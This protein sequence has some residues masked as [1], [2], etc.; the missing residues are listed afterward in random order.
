[1]KRS[2]EGDALAGITLIDTGILPGYSWHR[3][4]RIWRTPVLGEAF[5]AVSRGRAFTRGLA[6][7]EPRGLPA[8]FLAGMASHYD[9]RTKRAVLKLYR[10]TDEPGEGA[11][12]L[13]AAFAGREVPALV[14]WG[15]DDAYLPSSYAERQR[16]VFPAAEVHVLPDSGHWP[17]ADSPETV[18]RLLVEFL[19]R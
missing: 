13:R 10:A 11:E 2:C 17:F 6:S 19:R 5:Q 7:K 16:E 15:A 3:L 12:M 14:I 8:D 18:E 1:M 4:A 9:R